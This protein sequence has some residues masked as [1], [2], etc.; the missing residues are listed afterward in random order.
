MKRQSKNQRFPILLVLS[1]MMVAGFS[2]L[3]PFEE[4][5]Q[6][7]AQSASTSQSHAKDNPET[8][9]STKLQTANQAERSS[10]ILENQGRANQT[11]PPEL[12]INEFMADNDGIVTRPIDGVYHEPDWIEFFNGG[13][14]AVN[15]TGMYVTDNLSQPTRW[16]IT[17]ATT[18]QPGGHVVI[19]AT[20]NP[21]RGVNHA[22][23]GLRRRGDETIGLFMSDGTTLVDSFAF[24]PQIS[25]V[26]Y[27]RLPDGSNNWTGML[28]PTPEAANQANPADDKAPVAIAGPDTNGW[29][30]G[31]TRFDGLA[32]TDDKG[33]VN[34]TWSYQE[35]GTSKKFFGPDP[36]HVFEV[37]GVYTVT[38]T[39]I[40][41]QGNT[42]NDTLTV[43][44][45]PLEVPTTLFINEFL[46]YNRT[47]NPNLHPDL[48]PFTDWIEL[49]NSGDEALDLSGMYLTDD[50]AASDRWM[51]PAGTL[52]PA[53]GYV[54]FW[55]DGV[56]EEGSQHTG[57]R[58]NRYDEVVGL[59]ARDGETAIDTYHYGAQIADVS[60]GRIP[61]GGAWKPLLRPTAGKTNQDNGADS[62]DPVAYAG[63]NKEIERGKNAR[64]DGTTSLDNRGIVNYTWSFVYNGSNQV[65]YGPDPRFR[66]Q[67]NGVYTVTMK[68]EDAGGNTDM[69]TLTVKVTDPKDETSYMPFILTALILLGA[70][71]L[72]VLLLR[73]EHIRPGSFVQNGKGEGP[74]KLEEP[75]IGKV[76]DKEE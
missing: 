11:E 74:P 15:M 51:I 36:R 73:G 40:D 8:K 59:F 60:M 41:G 16:Q 9:A 53:K 49:Y 52:I 21:D 75:D 14:E 44:N 61:D 72:V 6:L 19:W 37:P 69:D 27:G 35:N 12:Y 46:A 39:V 56:L 65:L 48:T 38:L 55:A 25:N 66:F 62:E 24:G 76:P 43:I 3:F 10:N 31:R 2:G 22:S 28:S 30:G 50:L 32:S 5:P 17:A 68:V 7:P 13:D 71:L 42:N 23:F 29:A 1:L 54:V 63:S 58:L 33:I 57:F 47:S 70:L 67:V 20:S 45:T 64:F 26:S 18:I 34:F 4:A